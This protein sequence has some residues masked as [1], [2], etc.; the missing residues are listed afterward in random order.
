MGGKLVAIGRIA[1]DFHGVGAEVMDA[2]DADIAAFEDFD[3][4]VELGNFETMTEF[5][6]IDAEAEEFFH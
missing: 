4:A 3:D 6:R 1:R 5:D 2:R